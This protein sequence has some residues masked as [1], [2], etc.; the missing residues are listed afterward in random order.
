MGERGGFI[1][2]TDDKYQCKSKVVG[3]DP[4]KKTAATWVV[5]D[6]EKQGKHLSGQKTSVDDRYEVG[7]LFSGQ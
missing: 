6:P 4:G 5:H 2:K 1:Q 7:M 3:L